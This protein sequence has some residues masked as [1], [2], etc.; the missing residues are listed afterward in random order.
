[1]EILK[2]YRNKID[3]LDDKI[4]DLLAERVAIVR[5]V[6]AL[7]Y[8]E[9]IE[10]VLQDRVDEVRERAASRA[11]AKGIDPDLIYQFYTNLIAYSC[12][13]EEEIKEQM[14]KDYASSCEVSGG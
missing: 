12:R 5:E 14:A 4:V 7:K 6:G 2:P 13:L 11:A 10:P 1:M 9:N 3:E 8:R